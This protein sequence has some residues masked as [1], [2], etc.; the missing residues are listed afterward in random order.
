MPLRLLMIDLLILVPLIGSPAIAQEG[1]ADSS[2]QVLG[3]EGDLI[4]QV[5]D[6]SEKEE[7]DAL[8]R[9]LWLQDHP[10]DL[11]EASREELQTIPGVLPQEAMAMTQLRKALGRF[12]TIEQ[13]RALPEIG[14]DLYERIKMFVRLDEEGT[15]HQNMF[16][17]RSR[18]LRDLQPREGFLDNSYAGSSLKTYH[19]FI[20]AFH[21]DAE[22]G[23]LFEKDA[24]ETTGDGFVAGYALLRNVLFL[25]QIIIGDYGLEVGQGIAL[26]RASA[27][28]KSAD[29]VD[30]M[31]SGMGAT[32]YRS[33]DEFN[34]F[35]GI[36]T[37]FLT[38]LPGGVVSFNAFVSR[39]AIDGTLQPNGSISSF[40]DA[41]LFRTQNERAKKS[42]ARE[43]LFGATAK[44]SSRYEWSLG[45]AAYTSRFD[46]DILGDRL[47]E[48]NGTRLTVFSL[49]GNI[50]L[51]RMTLFGE[52]ATSGDGGLAGMAGLVLRAGRRTDIAILFRDLGPRYIA[53]H[54][55]S[56]DD[57]G[58]TNNERGMYVGL[59]QG[60][61]DWL[62]FSAYVDLFAHPWVTFSNPFPTSGRDIL[63]QVEA[64]PSRP[65]NLTFRVSS[66]ME[67]GA[68]NKEDPFGRSS[69]ARNIEYRD[70]FRL[71]GSYLVTKSFRLKGRIEI[72]NMHGSVGE[73][74]GILLFQDVR[75][76]SSGAW[77]AEARVVFFD[78]DSFDSRIYEYENDLRGVFSNQ[79]LFGKGRRWYLLAGISLLA[80]LQLTAKYSQTEK[81]GVTS[82]SSGPS[83]IKGS[84]D[85]RFALQLD[86]R[87]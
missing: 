10:F 80:H 28:G 85:T 82:L 65:L 70:R 18:G 23:G 40:Y 52:T 86:L 11:N 25:D 49:D 32:P 69:V 9:I 8:D 48:L 57:N 39:H 51:G 17:L 71:T 45:I 15:D 14:D 36:A 5:L 33:T 64:R 31:R 34:F 63:L 78:T 2:R 79:A 3:E 44:F 21:R 19:R 12:S 67:E 1:P 29:A 43:T 84:V 30:I 4:E 26:W 60:L 20:Y 87:F 27:F 50:R 55:N 41:G 56:F 47:G 58:Q 6:R 75:F 54:A 13:I 7:L 76:Q 72:S 83:L 59:R 61:F 42:V 53:L 73:E 37:N 68:I 24:G 77:F 16:Q 38:N 22:V 66:Q 46:R 81:E 35:R 74:S 62:K